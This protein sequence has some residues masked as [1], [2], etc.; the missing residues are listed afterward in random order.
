MRSTLKLRRG[1]N[2]LLQLA[3]HCKFFARHHDC[4]EM[5]AADLAL[6]EVRVS[7]IGLKMVVRHVCST[8]MVTC[9]G[10]RFGLRQQS[11]FMGFT[12]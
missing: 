1:E 2:S 3:S 6:Q 7:A 11:F 9:N 12:C 8:H 4:I 10:Q 5:K